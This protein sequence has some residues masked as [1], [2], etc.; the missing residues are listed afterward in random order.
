MRIHKIK[1]KMNAEWWS[2]I[3]AVLDTWENP[4]VSLDE[5]RD[6]VLVKELNHARKNGGVAW[7]VDSRKAKTSFPE[8]I[9]KFINTEV[10]PN[11]ARS[12]IKYFITINPDSDETY[13]TVDN[14]YSRIS[15]SGLELV[16]AKSLQDAET[17]LKD[18]R[19]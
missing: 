4:T 8:D 1:G 2:D 3:N 6:A 11:F 19:K 7:I 15:P 17:F 16:E 5:Y 9:Q 12:G 18:Q 13:H 14:Y 10:F